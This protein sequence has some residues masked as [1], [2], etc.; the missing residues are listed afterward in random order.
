MFDQHFV[1]SRY[2][3][4][5]HGFGFECQNDDA[6]FLALDSYGTPLK[7]SKGNP[8]RVSQEMKDEV[9]LVFVDI[10]RQSSQQI[11]ATQWTLYGKILKFI[12]NKIP[13]SKKEQFWNTVKSAF[14]SEIFDISPGSDLKSLE[15]QLKNSVKDQ[16][17]FDLIL[18]LSILDPV[19]AI[20]NVRPYYFRVYL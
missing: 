5:V 6:N 12:G 13:E 11:R 18:E 2:G 10:D 7:Y 3:M 20:K 15:K 19:E 4:E 1:D 8:V 14:N 16:T 9:P 17:G